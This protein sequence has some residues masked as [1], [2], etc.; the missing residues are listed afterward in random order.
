M[1]KKIRLIYFT[2]NYI[3]DND[4]PGQDLYYYYF[5]YMIQV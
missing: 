3:L 4:I 2:I 5:K 1:R